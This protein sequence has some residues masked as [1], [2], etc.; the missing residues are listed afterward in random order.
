MLLDS[1]VIN[2]DSL[3]LARIYNEV[4]TKWAFNLNK[5]HG[6]GQGRLSGVTWRM[7]MRLT[8]AAKAGSVAYV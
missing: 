3:N 7:T 1:P 5:A 8:V 2:Y 4:K 6:G